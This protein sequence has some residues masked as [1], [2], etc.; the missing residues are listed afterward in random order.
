MYFHRASGSRE[1]PAGLGIGD[2]IDHHSALLAEPDTTIKTPGPFSLV[3]ISKRPTAGGQQDRPDSLSFVSGDLFPVYQNVKRLSPLNTVTN[4]PVFHLHQQ[5]APRSDSRDHTIFLFLPS[6]S[7][8]DKIV[9]ISHGTKTR[10]L[11]RE[12]PF[13]LETFQ[14]FSSYVDII[15]GI[16]AKEGKEI[17]EPFIS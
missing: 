3:R 13:T 7:L 1:G 16:V 11:Q 17:C 10:I 6:I 15:Y 8:Q 4:S 5:T 9:S 14:V 2:A 12:P